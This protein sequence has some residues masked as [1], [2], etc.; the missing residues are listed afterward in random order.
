M[1]T[2][3]IVSTPFESPRYEQAL[4]LRDRLLRKPVGLVMTDEDRKGDAHREHI[5]AVEDETVIGCVS[6]YLEAP[7]I[8]RIKQMVVDPAYQGKGIGVQLMQA[9]EAAGYSEG[10]RTARLHAR[11]TAIEFYTRLDYNGVG[12][13]FLEK[14][15]PHLLMEKAL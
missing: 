2:Y 8:M 6:Y 13:L 10:A 12:E 1:S 15:I 14:T 7:N 5:V 11:N 9:A 4:A 3:T